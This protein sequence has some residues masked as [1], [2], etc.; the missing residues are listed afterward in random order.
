M[1]I[2]SHT[3]S[4]RHLIRTG[5]VILAPLAGSAL[6]PQMAAAGT[7]QVEQGVDDQGN[8]TARVVYRAQTGEM[9]YAQAWLA[10]ASAGLVFRVRDAHPDLPM[11]RAG[12]S[13]GPGCSQIFRDGQPLEARCS[14]P[15]DARAR[16]H[17]LILGDLDDV[18]Y[19]FDMAG[20]AV[21]GGPGDDEIHSWGLIDGGPDDDHLFGQ[22]GDDR[23]LGGDGQDR[24]DAGDGANR[25]VP[26]S[27]VDH[28]WGLGKGRGV[29]RS[30]DGQ[31]D[32][33]SCGRRGHYQ[34]LIDA[35]DYY[36]RGCGTVGRRGVARAVP[37]ELHYDSY[38]PEPW[39]LV[40]CP[41]DGAR[42]CAASVVVRHRGRVL[43]RPSFRNR[44]AGDIVE[45]SLS[46][47]LAEG[48][49]AEVTVSSRDR[50]GTRRVVRTRI[51]AGWR[52][53]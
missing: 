30:R 24:I 21:F 38:S 19:Q 32:W 49:V 20:S 45:L 44:R 17:K 9:N 12:V 14:L 22:A 31:P 43:G 26:G 50:E 40:G 37:L 6:F 27:G 4:V 25:I 2:E 39:L 3:S 35:L 15:S 51:R 28:V 7:A 10:S 33:I 47:E 46:S 42:K 48:E 5:V 36:G 29:V 41:P 34:L 13:A 11:R 53:M 1:R 52:G 16:G 18:A 8:R 23:V